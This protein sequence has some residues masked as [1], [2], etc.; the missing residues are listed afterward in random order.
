MKNADEQKKDLLDSYYYEYVPETFQWRRGG[1]VI[2]S[3][4]VELLSVKELRDVLE[5]NQKRIMKRD[6]LREKLEEERKRD[7]EQGDD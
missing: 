7:L 1:H 3:Y 6:P 4:E 5:K 2:Q